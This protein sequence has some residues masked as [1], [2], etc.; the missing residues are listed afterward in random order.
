MKIDFVITWVDGK[1]PGWIKERD[2]FVTS[3]ERN[4]SSSAGDQ[5]YIDDGLLNYI[6][7]GR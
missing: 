4:N 7:R 2:L 5:R 6:F 3:K 1:D